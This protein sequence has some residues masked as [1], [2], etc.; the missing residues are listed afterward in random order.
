M[1]DALSWVSTC[2]H[3]Y[4]IIVREMHLGIRYKKVH[5]VNSRDAFENDS[6]AKNC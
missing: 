2:F 1:I 5:F 4:Y 3:S 6:I